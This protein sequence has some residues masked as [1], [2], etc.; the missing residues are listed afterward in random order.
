MTDKD[1]KNPNAVSLGRLGGIKGGPARRASLTAVQRSD[2]GRYAAN[3]RWGH[4][5]KRVDHV[6]LA[7]GFNKDT[8]LWDVMLMYGIEGEDDLQ[9]CDFFISDAKNAVVALSKAVVKWDDNQS[10]SRRRLSPNA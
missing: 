2:I 6:S 7:A 8:G 4:G 3:T 1:G 9:E 10:L 5:D